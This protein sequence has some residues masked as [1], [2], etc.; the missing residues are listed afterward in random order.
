M[1]KRENMFYREA[2]LKLPAQNG[3][4]STLNPDNRSVE[5]IGATENPCPVY[6]WARSEI[7]NEVLLMSG[8]QLSEKGQIPL[9]DTHSRWDTSSV[10]GSFREMRI[11]NDKL[12]GRAFFSKA[13]EA[14][15]PF[16]KVSEGHL[17][18]FSAGYRV[19][20]SRYIPAGEEQNIAGRMFKGPVKITTKWAVK[21][22]S[23]CPIGA[24]EA[25]TVR[26][27]PANIK[28]EDIPMDKKV[29]TFLES[30][31]LPQNA[32]EEEAYRFLEGMPKEHVPQA[33]DLKIVQIEDAVRTAVRAEQDRVLEIRGL[34]GQAGIADEADK[35]IKD[36]KTVEQ[37]RVIAY[38]KLLAKVPTAGG[39]GYRAPI[40][41]GADERDK[42]RAAATDSI[43]IRSGR[44]IEK[45]ADGSRDLLGFSL[46]E[47]SRESLRIANKPAN[48]DALEMIGRALT[49]SD[50]P[51][52]LSNAANKSL[53]EGFE[54]AEESWEKWCDTG[55]VSDFKTNTSARASETDDLDEIREEDEYKYGA[56][57]EAKEEYRIA[58]YGKLFKI[59]RQT[60]VNDD[61]SALSDIPRKHGEAASR[62]IG[63]I[64][65]AVLTANAAMGDAVA[66]F[67]SGHGNLGT[68]GVVSET[69]IGEAIKLMKLQKDLNGKRRLN[70]RPQFFL[71]PVA[72]EGASEVFFNSMQ[73][74]GDNKAATRANPYSGSYFTRVYEARLD[75]ASSV[76]WYLAGPKGKTV[77][78][79]FLNGNRTPY[80]ETKEGW[81]I[82]GVE[83]K[84]RI[85][86][87][88]K[89]MDWKALI[90]NAG[91]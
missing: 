69:T 41:M 18:D 27:T 34:C 64:A 59:S 68:G 9:L 81:N 73:F 22:M 23:V 55:S 7:V 20:E 74:A 12:I 33:G 49:T 11:E 66:L 54:S 71:A 83:F 14:E 76:I 10:I 88:A 77:K 29:R 87:G 21:E 58:T 47:L 31:G 53:F 43:L 65:Y 89:A 2:A 48:G 79:F 15:A 19:I 13:Q 63:D 24:D 52:I 62:K 37:V 80:L 6:D 78:V 32:T 50:L 25:A 86:A 67:N 85:D 90:R 17:T 8:C 4:P 36:N 39:A 51:I 60:I 28:K 45:P 56:M 75:D 40:E 70:I 91:A 16:L 44:E 84:V 82:D 3:G 46:K 72:I 5:V 61:L 42:F 26:A 38:D 30:R 1:P 35:F 57:K